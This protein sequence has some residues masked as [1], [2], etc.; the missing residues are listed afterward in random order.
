MIKNEPLRRRLPR[1]HENPRTRRVRE[2]Q[3]R[4]IFDTKIF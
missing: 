2:A 1:T 4:K 3:T